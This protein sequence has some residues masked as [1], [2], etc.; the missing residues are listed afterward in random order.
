MPLPHTLFLLFASIRV[1]R[2]QTRC[3]SVLLGERRQAI[4]SY[5]EI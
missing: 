1:I 5:P 2:V 3:F 4:M